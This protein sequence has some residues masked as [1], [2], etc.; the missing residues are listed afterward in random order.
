MPLLLVADPDVDRR[1][2]HAGILR[3][4]GY[5]VAAVTA[6]ADAAGSFASAPPALIILQLVS[7]SADEFAACR[8]VRTST[9]TRDTPVLV[10]TRIDDPY[11]RDQIVRSGAT[12]IL[13]EPLRSALLLRQVRRLLAHAQHNA[14]S[15]RD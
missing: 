10:L 6:L 15:R 7:G 3:G 14:V 11:T 2:H 8:G 5:E 13:I 9:D 1:E 4:A 12:A